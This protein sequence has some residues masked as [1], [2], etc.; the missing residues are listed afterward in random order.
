MTD[1]IIEMATMSMDE[2]IV[3]LDKELQ[4]VRAGK[5]SPAMFNGVF[6]DYYGSKTLISQVANINASDARSLTIEPWEKNMLQPIEKAIF[7]ANLGV[8]PQNNG[9]M[10][11]INI[12]PLTEQRRKDLAKQVHA[13]GEN[14]KVSVRNARRDSNN[15][16][17]KLKSDLS[18]DIMKGVQKEIQDLTDSHIS[19]IEKV[20]SAKEAELMSI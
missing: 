3:H 4:T 10:I 9:E 11:R 14:A 18:E 5:A 6:V 13:M 7:A 17:K 2:A 20:V 15:E 12:P 16:L 8:T 19:K 1:D